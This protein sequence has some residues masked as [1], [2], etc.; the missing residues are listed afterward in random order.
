MQSVFASRLE[1]EMFHCVRHVH[2][3]SADAGV[4][5]RA[6]EKLA[7][8]TDKRMALKILFIP[9][10]FPNKNYASPRGAFAK[11]SLRGMKK[12][13]TSSALLNSLL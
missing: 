5:K 8:G 7:G 9:R 13:L 11:H 12:Q 2:I 10:L 4:M 1:F 6:V 3:R